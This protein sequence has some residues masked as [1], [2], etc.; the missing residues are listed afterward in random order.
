MAYIVRRDLTAQDLMIPSHN[1]NEYYG[2]EHL[3]T[4]RLIGSV[5]ETT[6]E[7]AEDGA[8]IKFQAPEGHFVFLDNIDLDWVTEEE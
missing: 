8:V 7:D 1:T 2:D 6:F 3:V 5:D 4:F